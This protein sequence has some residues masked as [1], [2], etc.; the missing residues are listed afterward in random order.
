MESASNADVGFMRIVLRR[1][2]YGDLGVKCW[3]GQENLAL[4]SDVSLISDKTINVTSSLFRFVCGVV[5]DSV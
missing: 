5:V 2:I 4:H 1:A 3:K